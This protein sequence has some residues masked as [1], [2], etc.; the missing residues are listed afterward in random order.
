MNKFTNIA[1]AIMALCLISCATHKK[2]ATTQSSS[3][4][5]RTDTTENRADT[6]AVKAVFVDTTKTE[7]I[8]VGGGV[9]EF[10][11]GGGKV[12]IDTEGNATFEG[13]KSVKGGRKGGLTQNKGIT[14]TAEQTEAHRE[15][16]NGITAKE[17]KQAVATTPVKNEGQKWYQTTF[18]RIGQIV[19]IAALLW[20]LFLY[21]KRKF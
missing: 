17:D 11:E 5:E 2:A 16:L 7:V 20:V 13:V 10:V 21:L 1:A 15:Q 4:V 3:T 8:G 12:S 14:Q 6:A 18:M 19:C 9:I